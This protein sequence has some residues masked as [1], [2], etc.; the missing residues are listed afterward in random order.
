[1][2]NLYGPTELT[3]AC[4]V[5]RW[6]G[7]DRPELGVVPIGSLHTGLNRL[8]L[9]DTGAGASEGELC[10]TGPQLFAG[11]L[12]PADDANRF[13]FRDGRRWYRTGDRVRLGEQ[14]GMHF[15]GRAD[16]QVQLRGHRV[17]PGEIE[18][19]IAGWDGVDQ[20]VVVAPATQ[21]GERALFVFYTGREHEPV[22]FA[23]RL[24][25]VLPQ[26]LVP[27]HYRRLPEFPLNANRKL[28]RG[29]LTRQAAAILWPSRRR[30]APVTY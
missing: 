13:H 20:A 27:R 26:D 1:V 4:S 25:P 15:L 18:H 3:I 7:P 6:T 14:G 29:E 9:D 17:E 10:V 23:R 2:D 24:Q 8:V 12:D 28:D 22:A 30:D 5:H 21:D 19:R 16:D 11:Y